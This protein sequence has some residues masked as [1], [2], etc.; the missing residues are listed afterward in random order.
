MTCFH[1]YVY[2]LLNACPCIICLKVPLF[3]HINQLKLLFRFLFQL[4]SPKHGVVHLV[5]WLAISCTLTQRCHQCLKYLSRSSRDFRLFYVEWQRSTLLQVGLNECPLSVKRNGPEF[6]KPQIC[7]YC[8][9]VPDGQVV[10][11]VKELLQ[12]FELTPS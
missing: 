5:L 4:R 8:M 12:P 2:L 10:I 1:M 3:L 7:L 9:I 6:L 11:A